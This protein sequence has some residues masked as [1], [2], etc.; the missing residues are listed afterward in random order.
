MT[1]QFSKQ[2]ELFWSCLLGVLNK[3]FAGIFVEPVFMQNLLF[4]EKRTWSNAEEFIKS[5]DKR[6]D[7]LLVIVQYPKRTELWPAPMT[8][9]RWPNGTYR[10]VFN[11]VKDFGLPLLDVMM[12][13]FTHVRWWN[14]DAT[15]KE[16]FSFMSKKLNKAILLSIHRDFRKQYDGLLNGIISMLRIHIMTDVD[17]KQM[18]NLAVESALFGFALETHEGP[19]EVEQFIQ[20]LEKHLTEWNYDENVA[21]FTA[22][23]WGVIDYCQR[24]RKFF[25]H[26]TI[27]ILDWLIPYLSKEGAWE[28]AVNDNFGVLIQELEQVVGRYEKVV[29]WMQELEN[30]GAENSQSTALQ[31][32]QY[33]N[34]YTCVV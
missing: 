5:L 18:T 10:K 32:T 17:L 9:G 11:F 21:D 24:E 4:G 33:S 7:D 12:R 15:R 20:L 16:P 25:H 29:G 23:D 30:T 6:F 34:I 22:E 26:Y 28:E 13:S 2:Y 14:Q 27:P 31:R 3:H 1:D 19:F 8:K